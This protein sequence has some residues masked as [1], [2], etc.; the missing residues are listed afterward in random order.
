M[1]H[2]ASICSSC[3]NLSAPLLAAPPPPPL[4][5]WR[6]GLLEEWRSGPGQLIAG[7][8]IWTTPRMVERSRAGRTRQLWH[9]EAMLAS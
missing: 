1:L 6:G 3:N 7:F 4:V 5:W 9:S 2:R 8:T